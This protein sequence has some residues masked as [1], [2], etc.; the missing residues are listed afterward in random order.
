MISR[1]LL[2]VNDSPAALAATRVAIGLA[3]ACHADLRAVHVLADGDLTAAL[4]A[5]SA[6]AR[7]DG[8]D[9]MARRRDT[10]GE[11]LLRHVADLGRGAGLAVD[12]RQVWGEPASAVLA[13]A[14]SWHADLIVLG[15]S[16]VPGPH[17]RLGSQALGVLEFAEQPVLVVPPPAGS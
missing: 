7:A 4:A 10:A 3:G 2:A 14:V 17:P 1:I 15:R 9:A 11:A 5:V 8:V 6:E 13:E 12:A 16:D